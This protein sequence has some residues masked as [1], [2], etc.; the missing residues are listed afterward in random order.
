MPVTQ[1]QKGIIYMILSALSFAAMQVVVRLTREIPTMEQ[2]FM[3]NLFILIAA[4]YM[5]HRNGGSYF[6]ERKYQV[7]LFGRSVSGFLGLVTLFYASSHAA[8]GDVT[9][10]NKLSPI[11]VTLLAVVFMKEKMLPIQVPALA[12]AGLGASIVFRPRCQLS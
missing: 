2:I 4:C 8:Q 3:R 5:I 1:K 11:F 6:G 9:I 12:R 10:L 7:G